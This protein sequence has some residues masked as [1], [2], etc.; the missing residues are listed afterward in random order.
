MSGACFKMS[1]GVGKEKVGVYM[2]QDW[3]LVDYS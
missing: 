2:K 1:H 3:K